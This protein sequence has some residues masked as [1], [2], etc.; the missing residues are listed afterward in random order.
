MGH[1]GSSTLSFGGVGTLCFSVCHKKINNSL[2]F[3][4]SADIL[5]MMMKTAGDGDDDD[6]AHL[7]LSQGDR[8]GN[9]AE[10]EVG[11]GKVEDQ[12]IPEHCLLK[13]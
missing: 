2:H 13:F 11:Q 3:T 12:K 9:D 10:P 6:D 7:D 5:L 1:T 4:R 8:H